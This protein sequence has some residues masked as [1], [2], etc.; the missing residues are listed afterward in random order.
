MPA[1]RHENKKTPPWA[2]RVFGAKK[3]SEEAKTR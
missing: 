3:K 1:A 2:G